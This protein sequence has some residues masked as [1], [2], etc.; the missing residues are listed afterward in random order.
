MGEVYLA[1]DLKLDRQVAIKL[2][3]E[4]LTKD[5]DIVERFEREAKAA[6][7]LD[8]NNICAIYEIDETEN[9]Q[10]FISMAYYEGETLNEKVKQKPLPLKEAIDIAFQ[11]AQGLAKAHEKVIVH[12]VIKPANIMHTDDGVVKTLDFGLAKLLKQT[13]LTNESTTL[14]TVSYMFPEQAK[15]ALDCG[16]KF[17]VSPGF[18]PKVVQYCLQQKVTVTPRVCTPSEFTLVL[19]HG[20]SVLKFFPAEVPSGLTT[21]STLTRAR[22]RFLVK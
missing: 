5:K 21:V 20:L 14:G 19:E 16:V 22:V 15:L 7:S 9:G 4:H 1:D 17:I 6:T 11:I 13:K 3:P 10:L 18:N 2:L 8:H 12:R